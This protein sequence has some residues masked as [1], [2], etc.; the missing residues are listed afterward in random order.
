MPLPWYGQLLYHESI[1]KNRSNQHFTENNSP[2]SGK[3]VFP[4]LPGKRGEGV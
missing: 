3:T 2:F 1:L 4:Q